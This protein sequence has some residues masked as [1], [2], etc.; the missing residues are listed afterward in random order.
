MYI[1]QLYLRYTDIVQVGRWK[2]YTYRLVFEQANTFMVL[3][4]CVCVCVCICTPLVVLQDA[5]FKLELLCGHHIII[6]GS[7]VLRE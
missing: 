4:V 2:D 6:M 7:V 5:L 1:H 3:P